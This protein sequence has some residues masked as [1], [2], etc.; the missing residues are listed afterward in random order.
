MYS[1]GDHVII[2]SLDTYWIAFY[3]WESGELLRV[4]LAAS[5]EAHDF[6]FQYPTLLRVVDN[7]YITT[8]GTF[9]IEQE[10]DNF[11][12]RIIDCSL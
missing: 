4:A 1:A 11:S 6:L 9:V 7:K 12:C 3:C 10:T 5:P 2:V 8:K